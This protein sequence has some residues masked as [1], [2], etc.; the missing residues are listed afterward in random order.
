MLTAGDVEEM[1]EV[2]VRTCLDEF[3]ATRAYFHHA[4]PQSIEQN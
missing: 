2:P 1:T 3:G 4:T